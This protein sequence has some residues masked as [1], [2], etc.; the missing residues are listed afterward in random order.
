ML[1]AYHTL[2]SRF[3]TLATFTGSLTFNFFFDS[4]SCCEHCMAIRYRTMD[5]THTT[6]DS[7]PLCP[8]SISSPKGKRVFCGQVQLDS[9]YGN[10]DEDLA[11][12]ES[13]LRKCF[14]AL[15]D[16]HVV[17]RTSFHYKDG[18][19][20]ATVHEQYTVAAD[21]EIVTSSIH[22]AG[23]IDKFVEGDAS[24][25]LPDRGSSLI[26]SRLFRSRDD[27][28]GDILVM[29]APSAVVD[30]KSMALIF[31]DLKVLYESVTMDD[32]V[33]LP[34]LMDFMDY[35]LWR[36]ETAANFNGDSNEAS[37][38]HW[39]DTLTLPLPVLQLPTDRSRKGQSSVHT[40]SC[41]LT[42]EVD[43]RSMVGTVA[44]NIAMSGIA[45]SEL[46][47]S[48]G[49]LGI[50]VVASRI[51]DRSLESSFDVQSFF[52][53]CFQAMVHRF[54]AADDIIVGCSMSGRSGMVEIA[55]GVGCCETYVLL[56][57]RCS[58]NPTFISFFAARFGLASLLLRRTTRAAFT[59]SCLK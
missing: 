24:L 13:R 12:N 59:M 51:I 41:A 1:K 30:T 20:G 38:Q 32:K 34:P 48:D 4:I 43:L 19:W 26:R 6:F 53:A 39:R 11:L 3:A 55:D 29:T 22:D 31:E 28:S 57:T 10:E 40:R 2:N 23:L 52:L 27:N 36:K 37:V 47:E 42:I 44:S 54:S 9:K 8:P 33:V 14:Q 17:L 18:S 49:G 25:S 46:Q 58:G 45:K 50:D 7:L 35:M 15:T 16:R 5:A 21:F 56:R